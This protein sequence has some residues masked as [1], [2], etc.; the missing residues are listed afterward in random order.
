MIIN[1]TMVIIIRHCYLREWKLIFMSLLLK[2][3]CMIKRQQYPQKLWLS[4]LCIFL[5]SSVSFSS[6]WLL[7]S[8]MQSGVVTLWLEVMSEGCFSSTSS[9]KLGQLWDQTWLLRTSY[10]WVTRTLM[11]KDDTRSLANLLPC[12]T[13]FMGKMLS[14]IASQNFLFQLVIMLLPGTTVKVLARSFK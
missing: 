2:C 14:L 8:F 12:C 7:Y 9:S 4:K 10:I 5:L 1:E 13:A 6:P 11:G 3:M